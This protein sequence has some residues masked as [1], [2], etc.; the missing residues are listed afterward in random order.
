MGCYDSVFFK[1]PKCGDRLEAQSKAS[2]CRLRDIDCDKVPIEIADDL[3][4]EPIYCEPCGMRYVMAKLD[5]PPPKT[6]H[7]A[8]II[9]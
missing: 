7:M 1:C 2:D 8:L 4:G 3:N 6:V 5:L 9:K